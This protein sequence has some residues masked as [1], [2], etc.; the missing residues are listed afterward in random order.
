MKLALVLLFLSITL[1]V[2]YKKRIRVET[3]ADCK[4]KIILDGG[5]SGTSGTIALVD[6]GK[7]N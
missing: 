1:S 2:T 6:D 4:F 5:S 3:K 7:L